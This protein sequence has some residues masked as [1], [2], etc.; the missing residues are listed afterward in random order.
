[1]ASIQFIGSY[2]AGNFH[3]AGT[4]GTIKIT[5]PGGVTDGGTVS[6]SMAPTWPHDGIDLPDIAFGAHTTLAYSENAA[7]TGGTLTVSDGRHAA[8]IVLFGNYMAGSFVTAADGHGGTLV[9][10]AEQTSQPL[11]ARPRG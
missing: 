3:I 6:T 2:S 4:S 10:A 1:M 8:S 5:D 9:T 7:G 11:L